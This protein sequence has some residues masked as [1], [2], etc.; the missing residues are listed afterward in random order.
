MSRTC[1]MAGGEIVCLVGSG[2]RGGAN[3]Q[4][5]AEAGKGAGPQS[6]P[7]DAGA[8]AEGLAEGVAHGEA[9]VLVGVVVVDVRVPRG[10]DRDVKEPVAGDLV[11]HMVKEGNAG[12]G[13]G[14]PGAVEVQCDRHVRLFGLARDAGLALCGL[15]WLMGRS[16]G[17]GLAFPGNPRAVGSGG[18]KTLLAHGDKFTHVRPVRWRLPDFSTEKPSERDLS[19]SEK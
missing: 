16:S 7:V 8:V 17:R 19:F 11:E 4:G 13:V 3:G 5:G 9:N 18:V 14:L 6:S 1:E 12:R 10:L 2:R 15:G